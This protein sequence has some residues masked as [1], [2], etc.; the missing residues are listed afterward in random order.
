MCLL[1]VFF[2]AAGGEG[3]EG[4]V[5][6]LFEPASGLAKFDEGGHLP[7]RVAPDRLGGVPPGDQGLDRGG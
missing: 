5:L 6:R 1:Q 7:E 4:E 2:L 3:R